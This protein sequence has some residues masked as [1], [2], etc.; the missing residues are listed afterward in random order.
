MCKDL[1]GWQSTSTLVDYTRN[2]FRHGHDVWASG[3]R[4]L[5]ASATS[6]PSSR[7]FFPRKGMARSDWFSIPP[8]S[9][10]INL[11]PNMRNMNEAALYTGIGFWSI[12]M[13]PSVAGTDTAVR[14]VGAPWIRPR[15]FRAVSEC[16]PNPG[17]PIR[18]NPGFTPAKDAKVRR[19]AR[20]RA[21]R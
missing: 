19:T 5:T 17:C 14:G 3:G 16:T 15:V 11:S 2:R 8:R 6:T 20:W 12:R 4:C 13:Y 10:W 9:V 7:W 1:S 18:A 21:A